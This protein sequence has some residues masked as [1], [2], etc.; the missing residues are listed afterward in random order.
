MTFHKRVYSF[1]IE[2]NLWVTLKWVELKTGPITYVCIDIPWIFWGQ[3]D[4]YFM[5]SKLSTIM[6]D[7]KGQLV[8]EAFIIM[9][10]I[11]S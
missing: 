10:L 7:G 8:K 11:I 4:I 9:S 2:L 3:Y 6:Q 5:V 1:R